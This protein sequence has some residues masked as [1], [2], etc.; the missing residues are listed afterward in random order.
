MPNAERLIHPF[1]GLIIV[2]HFLQGYL[3]IWLRC[4]NMCKIQL[5]VF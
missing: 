4:C 5:L 2:I 1:L 3:Q